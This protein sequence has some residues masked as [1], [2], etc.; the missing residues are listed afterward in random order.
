MRGKLK[1]SQVAE[2]GVSSPQ[3][4]KSPD[5]SAHVLTK[6]RNLLLV[7]VKKKRKETFSILQGSGIVTFV[8]TPSIYKF[9]G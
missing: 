6:G 2:Q 8:M 5:P 3:P 4:Q 9:L 7:I 1:I